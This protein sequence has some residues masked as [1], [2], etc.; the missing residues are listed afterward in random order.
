M[1]SINNLN[2]FNQN[3]DGLKQLATALDKSSSSVQKKL[4][5]IKGR[6]IV[7]LSKK[8]HI[9]KW[10]AKYIDLH[11]RLEKAVN[12][13]E[14]KGEKTKI[15][16]NVIKTLQE[17]K[18]I[19]N[20]IANK[21][22]Y[23]AFI[24]AVQSEQAT[25]ADETKLVT[26]LN[27]NDKPTHSNLREWKLNFGLL[28]SA[29]QRTQNEETRATIRFLM[30]NYLTKAAFLNES[31]GVNLSDEQN[32]QNYQE[33]L[34]LGLFT[35]GG[36]YHRTVDTTAPILQILGLQDDVGSPQEKAADLIPMDTREVQGLYNIGFVTTPDITKP[37][38][39]VEILVSQFEAHV[40]QFSN[41]VPDDSDMKFP[42][43]EFPV[44]LDITEQ[45][46]QSLI[47]HGDPQKIREY[48]DKQ[49][50]VRVQINE[51]VKMAATIIKNKY[52]DRQDIQ[53]KAED[54]IKTNLAVVSR[55]QLNDHVA[56][57][58]THRN[59]FT[60]TDFNELGEQFDNPLWIKRYLFLTEKLKEWAGHS[61]INV[62]A[63]NLR[64]AIA[65]THTDPSQI[66]HIGRGQAVNYTV[67]GRTD[68]MVYPEPNNITRTNTF[69][70]LTRIAETPNPHI[71]EGQVLLAKA[72]VKMMNTLMDKITKEGWTEKQKDLAVRELT[73]TA[74]FRIQQHLAAAVHH[75][76]DLRQFSQAIDRTHAELTT[77]LALYS[78]FN[79]HSFDEKYANFIKPNFPDAMK[80]TLVGIA[81][82]AMNVFAGVNAAVLKNSPNPIRICGEHSYYEEAMVVGG[83]RT[84]N[85]VLENPD[86]NKVDLY[87]AEFYHNIDIDPHHTN[88]QKGTVIQDIKNIF[89]RKPDTDRLTVAIDATIDFTQS[90][91]IKELLETFKQEITEGKLNIV[92]FRSGQKFDMLGLDN[93]YGSLYYMVNNGDDKW[94]EFN[95]I[96]T[97]EAFH[98]DKLSQQFFSWMAEAGSESVEQYKKQVFDNARTI[99]DLVPTALQPEEGKEVCVCHFEE[100]VKTSFIDIKIDLADD[101]QKDELRRWTQQRFMELFIAENK[102]VYQRGSFGF[103]H[104]N[105]TW[106]DPKMRINPGLNSEENKLYQ[107]FFNELAAKVEEIQQSNA[108]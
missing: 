16:E 13:V 108:I 52:P 82:S 85:E 93:Y 103:A 17:S 8:E 24:K 46:G 84:L 96:K 100:D 44:L 81:K 66:S 69:K 73:Q 6:N 21:V 63:V 40:D 49:Q 76:H 27:P 2:P 62:G 9:P 11:K 98:T 86:I 30:A 50:V 53:D 51:I 32:V 25:Y 1:S 95:K 89:A 33:M 107:Q 64:R 59:I 105:I 102:L 28:H 12:E 101:L 99:L 57:M 5:K 87:V 48:E 35:M 71:G 83:N 94:S 47:T 88:Y 78:P 34:Q 92:V 38:E 97:E 22:N 4:A 68:V 60:S 54:Y 80:P 7:R 70:M 45:I 61:A 39:I 65:D 31:A 56:V 67:P 18:L 36:M 10:A 23:S 14:A 42:L 77:L 26:P 79:T 90:E 3:I 41:P 91:N 29:Y 55:A 74:V 20:E 75:A 58:G 106:I 37:D 72:T 43:M 104:A 19:I 15:P